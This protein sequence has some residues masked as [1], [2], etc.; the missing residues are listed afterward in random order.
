MTEDSPLRDTAD[1]RSWSDN[2]NVV[3]REVDSLAGDM[4]V[5]KLLQL[6]ASISRLAALDYALG[7]TTREHAASTARLA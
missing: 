5:P 1:D 2:A 7:V 4:A 6:S 3:V